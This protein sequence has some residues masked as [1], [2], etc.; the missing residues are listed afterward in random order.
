MYSKENATKVNF[1]TFQL[2]LDSFIFQVL[3]KLNVIVVIV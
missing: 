3:D 2:N 1:I